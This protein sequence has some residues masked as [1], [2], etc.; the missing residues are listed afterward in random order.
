MMSSSRCMDEIVPPTNIISNTYTK[1]VLSLDPQNQTLWFVGYSS[2]TSSSNRKDHDDS[3]YPY[4]RASTTTTTS[5]NDSSLSKGRI[6]LASQ[7]CC[8]QEMLSLLQSLCTEEGPIPHQHWCDLILQHH[9]PHEPHRIAFVPNLNMMERHTLPTYVYRWDLA[10]LWPP[11]HHSPTYGCNT[12]TTTSGTTSTNNPYFDQW[13]VYKN[14]S[15]Q[16][17]YSISPFVLYKDSPYHDDSTTTYSSSPMQLLGQGL[18]RTLSYT[19]RYQQVVAS[20]SDG[21]A[22]TIVFFQLL[23]QE[24]YVDTLPT[25]CHI[26]ESN[27][28]NKEVPPHQFSQSCQINTYLHQPMDVEQPSF[29]SSPSIIAYALRMVPAPTST[30]APSILN[31]RN[32]ISKTTHS[33]SLLVVTLQWEITLHFRYP[34]TAASHHRTAQVIIDPPFPLI[35]SYVVPPTTNTTITTTTSTLVSIITSIPAGSD[36]DL[37]LVSIITHL[38]MFLGCAYMLRSILQY[39]TQ[40]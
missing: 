25:K 23:P 11:V 3:R 12:T 35:S 37:L 15:V 26:L 21:N 22:N 33:A 16:K 31:S 19:H 9:L 32:T 20:S 39:N 1:A 13:I 4:C 18:H 7:S 29:N 38:I 30:S 2:T 10:L 27:I 6:L 17:S 24:T 5:S 14:H 40:K 8:F 34:S 36:N 28:I